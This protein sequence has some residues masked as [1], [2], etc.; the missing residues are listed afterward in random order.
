MPPWAGQGMNTG[1]RDVTNLC[2]KLAAIVQ[3]P[4]DHSLFDTYDH[5]RRPHAQAMID[6][7]TT[8]GRILSP[9]RRSLAHARNWF[10]RTASLAPAVKRWILEMRFKPIPHHQRGFV[11]PEGPDKR[12]P[13]VGRM[14]VQPSVETTAG[15]HL[16]LDDVL[17]PWFAV[18]GFECDPLA[19]LS[20]TE[21]TVV[22]TFKPHIV[23][24]IESRAGQ[25]WRR[26]RCAD[27]DTIVVED[28]HNQL[29]PWFQ[30]RGRNVVLV[31]PDR[32]VAAM[33]TPDALGSAVTNLAGQFSASGTDRRG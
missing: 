6:L 21:L 22:R 17:G 5:E 23:K 25:R 26:Q 27:P 9:T 1:I 15:T 30:A 31:R 2:W 33:T 7:S 14:F 3:D 29:R 24:I 16:R 4:A 8:L 11:V 12:P 32:Y 13:G 20:D 19:E 28:V 18:I 10:L